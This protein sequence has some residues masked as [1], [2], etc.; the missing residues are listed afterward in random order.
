MRRRRWPALIPLLGLTAACAVLAKEVH[1]RLEPPSLPPALAN[2]P[3]DVATRAERAEAPQLDTPE[4]ELPESE[5][6]AIVVDANIFSPKREPPPVQADDDEKAEPDAELRLVLSGV[7]LSEEQRIAI[8]SKRDGPGSVRISQGDSYRGW[9]LVELQRHAAIFSDGMRQAEF[10]LAFADNAG[11][12]A[13]PPSDDLEMIV[14]IFPDK[15]L[16][17]D[18][19]RTREALSLRRSSTSGGPVRATQQENLSA[20]VN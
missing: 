4:F 13:D 20:P 6:F 15:D 12:D 10:A 17:F 8:L 19:T 3:E 18:E 16:L 7:V 5:S 11:D 9:R 2:A 14:D 1:E